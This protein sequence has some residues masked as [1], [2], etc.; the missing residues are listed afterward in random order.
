MGAPNVLLGTGAGAATSMAKAAV[1]GGVG[2]VAALGA[3]AAVFTIAGM[4]HGMLGSAGGG[5]GGGSSE[6]PSFDID[7]AAGD[8]QIRSICH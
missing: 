4:K 5:G 6:D 7:E 8:T 1:A 3:A 2:A